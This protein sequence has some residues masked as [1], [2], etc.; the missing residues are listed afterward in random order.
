MEQSSSR[1]GST[2]CSDVLMAKVC[3][4]FRGNNFCLRMH[5]WGLGGVRGTEGCLECMEC[6]VRLPPRQKGEQ[7][8][9]PVTLALGEQRQEDHKFKGTLSCTVTLRLAWA[10][11]DLICVFLKREMTMFLQMP[12]LVSIPRLPVV[13]MDHLRPDLIPTCTWGK[14]NRLR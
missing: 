9:I 3:A 14:K 13:E 2:S 5:E 11:R 12:G 4:W 1:A 10:T 7:W 8:H 6:G